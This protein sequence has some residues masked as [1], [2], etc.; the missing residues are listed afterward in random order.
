MCG[1]A[2][3]IQVQE[4]GFESSPK[5]LLPSV[6]ESSCQQMRNNR[7]EK[8]ISSRYVS[9][10]IAQGTR[11]NHSKMPPDDTAM[12]APHRSRAVLNKEKACQIF[13][14]RGLVY[15]DQNGKFVQSSSNS[16]ALAYGVSP[17]TIRD[18]WNGR[19]WSH[20]T[21]PLVEAMMEVCAQRAC[22]MILLRSTRSSLISS[23]AS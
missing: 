22:C 8:K 15:C 14:S 11:L 9:Y 16:L 17:K 10:R 7:I 18:I 5:T 12:A 13:C 6:M 2:L 1:W 3:S 20:V 19:T 4:K 21:G 23:A